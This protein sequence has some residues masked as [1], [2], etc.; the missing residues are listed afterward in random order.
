MCGFCM[1]VHQKGDHPFSFVGMIRDINRLYLTVR[2]TAP[3]PMTEVF[4]FL[5]KAFWKIS[6]D[7][8]GGG[9]VGGGYRSIR[10]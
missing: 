9:R 4:F 6:N 8:L 5:K 7:G 2:Q 10:C 3:A 1:R